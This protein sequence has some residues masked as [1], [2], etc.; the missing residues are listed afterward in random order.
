M[1]DEK[2]THRYSNIRRNEASAILETRSAQDMAFFYSRDDVLFGLSICLVLPDAEAFA[3]PL[4]VII[5]G[6]A[7]P[8]FECQRSDLRNL[9]QAIHGRSPMETLLS[10]RLAVASLISTTKG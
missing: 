2:L 3:V 8:S 1:N 10:S 5:T 7:C 4:L 6:G 9:A